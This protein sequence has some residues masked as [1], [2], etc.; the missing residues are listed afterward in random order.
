M[1]SAAPL[2][3]DRDP[4]FPMGLQLFSIHDAMTDDAVASLGAIAKM[5]YRDVEIFGFD[6]DRGTFYDR[7]AAEFRTLL[8]DHGL[9]ASSGHFGFA[10]YLYRPAD[11]MTAFVDQCIRGARTLGLSY[12]AWPWMAPEQRTAATFEFLPDLLNSIGARVRAAGLGFAYHNHGFEFE[13]I[14]GRVPF[15]G[16]AKKTDPGLVELE[17]DMYWLIRSSDLTPRQM[18]DRYPGRVTLW[19]VKDMDK[20]TE[21]YTELGRG[22]IDYPNLLPDPDRSGLKF[23]YVEQ[24]GNFASSSLES[25]ATNARYYKKH[26]Q[27]FL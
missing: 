12:I 1:L 10:S 26:L 11:E 19:H 18:V 9:T 14:N 24:G 7:P 22:S 8:D 6:G 25:A 20:K 13:P 15:D 27:R 3:Q 5:G 23:C 16:I 4:R 17:L 21:D 2:S